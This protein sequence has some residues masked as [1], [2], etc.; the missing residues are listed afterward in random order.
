MLLPGCQ[1]RPAQG[2][3]HRA[4][5]SSSS[6]GRTDPVT[7]PLWH[8]HKG[9]QA[10]A[11]SQLLLLPLNLP[12][13]ESGSVTRETVQAGR[14]EA[15]PSWSEPGAQPSPCRTSGKGRNETCKFGL[16]TRGMKCIDRTCA[17]AHTSALWNHR[18]QGA[19]ASG[20][21]G[22]DF[23]LLAGQRILQPVW[24]LGQPWDCVPW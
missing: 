17:S 9:N 16:R 3:G 15:L 14:L 20:P 21:H 22:H 10:R 24:R 1:P 18:L 23:I 11:A 19:R 7:F 8:F 12:T 5:F 6:S 2:A 4:L 13:S